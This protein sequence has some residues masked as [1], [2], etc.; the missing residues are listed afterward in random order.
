VRF[1]ALSAASVLLFLIPIGSS[2]T[3]GLVEGK[4]I[5]FSRKSSSPKGVENGFEKVEP[6]EL[7]PV[8]VEVIR[9]ILVASCPG[10][11]E[12]IDMASIP[13]R[14]RSSNASNEGN[15]KVEEEEG[16]KNESTLSLNGVVQVPG[17]R[18]A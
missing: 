15:R 13:Q 17:A 9:S 16:S 2:T 14:V 8:L 10:E 4:G 6:L 18:F 7:G 1:R 5:S 11:V 3:R 12:I